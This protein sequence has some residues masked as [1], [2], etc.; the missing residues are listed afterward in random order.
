[1]KKVLKITGIVILILIAIPLIAALFVKKTYNVEKEVTIQKPKGVVYD[2]VKFLK[3]QDNYSVWLKM[4]PNA[5]KE[6]KGTD[7]TVGFISAWSSENKD[8]GKGE[9]EIKGIKEGERIDYEVRFKEPM[10]ST[11]KAWMTFESPDSTSTIVKWG[12]NGKMNYPMNLMMLFMDI[13]GMVGK[14]LQSGLD[15]LKIIMEK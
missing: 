3:N 11:E 6:F 2:Y 4:D 10:E 14:D 13:E 1:M 5:K 15:D 8:L 7:G 9:Q 12:F